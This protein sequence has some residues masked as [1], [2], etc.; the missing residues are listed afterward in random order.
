MRTR[1]AH[2]YTTFGMVSASHGRTARSTV[3][4]LAFGPLTVWAPR[5][6][7]RF[8]KEPLEVWAIGVWAEQTPA[9]EEPLEWILL[10]SVP[11]TTLEQAWERVGWYEHRWVVEDYHQCLKTGCRFEE[12]QVQTAARLI[13]LLGLLSKLSVRLLH[14]R[15]LARREPERPACE[16]LHADL[17]AIVAA[18]TGQVP[19]CMTTEAF[20]K[21]VAQMGA[22][23]PA[24][25][26]VLP[27]GKPCGRAGFASKRCWRAFIWL[28]ISVCKLCIKD[29]RERRGLLARW[30]EKG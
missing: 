25:V 23:W 16:V 12:R 19:A 29:R 14:L 8:S 10:T 2:S 18:Q 9:G 7:K 5:F 28:F 13:R 17:L 3:V 30:G 26:M 24:M 20:W 27:V 15:D 21:A 22:I 4:Q 1:K 11:T 6:E